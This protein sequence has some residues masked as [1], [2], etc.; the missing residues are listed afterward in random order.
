MFWKLQGVPFRSST[1]PEV[2]FARVVL[3]RDV[4]ENMISFF[5]CKGQL[6]G[7]KEA[8]LTPPCHHLGSR[9]L[10]MTNDDGSRLLYSELQIPKGCIPKGVS[11][12]PPLL[13]LRVTM[14]PLAAL[15]PF[16]SLGLTLLVLAHLGSAVAQPPEPALQALALANHDGIAPALAPILLAPA[17]DGVALE[18]VNVVSLVTR[19][20]GFDL[21]VSLHIPFT[22]ADG[23]VDWLNER[24]EDFFASLLHMGQAHRQDYW[25]SPVLLICHLCVGMMRA[26]LAVSSSLFLFVARAALTIVITVRRVANGVATSAW[27]V[28]SGVWFEPI[29]L[30]VFSPQCSAA[31]WPCWLCC[32]ARCAAQRRRGIS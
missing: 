21:R 2:F 32:T 24:A 28:A 18:L 20:G 26:T 10:K 13:I 8:M 4:P 11:H 3:K 25:L 31:L 16:S 9:I 1:H 15:M 6:S 19:A 22:D 23:L 12:P 27:R 30:P 29:S 7:G 17:P 5:F 14:A